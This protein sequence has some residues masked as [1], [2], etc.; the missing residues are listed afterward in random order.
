MLA[1]LVNF[2]LSRHCPRQAC[3]PVVLFVNG[4]SSLHPWLFQQMV[5]DKLV[6]FL[7]ENSFLCLFFISV[8]LHHGFVS[9]LCDYVPWTDSPPLPGAHCLL[10]AK[11][12]LHLSLST[13]GD[14]KI[15]SQLPTR[16]FKQAWHTFPTLLPI[17]MY[18]LS[19]PRLIKILEYV[20]NSEITTSFTLILRI[21]C[22][23]KPELDHVC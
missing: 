18:L 21:L 6:C 3:W 1:V 11:L 20:L 19:F 23:R 5:T 8:L 2:H 9:Y 12:W 15:S 13:F 10:V 7:L 22:P 16:S 17:Q 14:L 4:V